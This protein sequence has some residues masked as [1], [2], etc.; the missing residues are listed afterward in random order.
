MKKIEKVKQRKRRMRA[1]RIRA[2]L[3][4]RSDCPRLSV[5][6]SSRHIYGQVI[7]SA[8]RVLVAISDTHLKNTKLTGVTR[9]EAAGKLLAQ[10]AKEKNISKVVFDKGRYTFHGRVKAFA[11]GARAGGLLL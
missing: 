9:A 1:R 7:D 5:F 10:R 11:D 4:V 3:L 8:G 6:R 2:K